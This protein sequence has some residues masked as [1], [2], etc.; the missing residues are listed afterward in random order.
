MGEDYTQWRWGDAHRLT[1]NHAMGEVLSFLNVGD[2]PMPGANEVL[3]NL[4]YHYDSAFHQNIHFGPSTR[5]I[6]DFS[7]VRN[8]SWSIL[9]TG[10]SGVY[11]SEYYDD[12]AEMFANGEFRRMIMDHETIKQSEKKLVLSPE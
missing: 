3:N 4:G 12:Q 6:I 8:N 10:Q 9:P 2:F 1:H 7:N 11:F 5:R